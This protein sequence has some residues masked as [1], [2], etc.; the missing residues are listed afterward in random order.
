MKSSFYTVFF[1]TLMLSGCET[2][3]IAPTTD[4]TENTETPAP[5]EPTPAPVVVAPRYLYVA[6]GSCYG[7]DVTAGAVATGSNTVVRY[8]IDTGAFDSLITDYNSA[9]GEAP[10]AIV[11]YSD[12]ELLVLVEST[13][14]RRVDRVNKMTGARSSFLTNSFLSTQARDLT[15]LADGGLLISRNTAIEKFNS[16]RNRIM[17]GVTSFVVSPAAPCA[18]ATTLISGMT[19]LPGGNFVFAHA[20]AT[21]NNRIGIIKSTGYSVAGD[22][23]AG[24]TVSTTTALPTALITEKNSGHVLVA[25]G[26]ATSAS[27][28]IQS[29]V[30]TPATGAV[31]ASTLAYTD[32]NYVTAPS[33]LVQDTTTNL[34]YV[35]NARA[36]HNSI[37][38]FTYD[39][40]TRLLTRVSP[41]F[42]T[43]SIYT[44]CVAGM[45][46]GN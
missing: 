46:I 22:C 37:E 7:G 11:N 29:F 45:A 13:G 16:N 35:A 44:R 8:N 30:I 32:F 28:F 26:S 25:A 3:R 2:K 23:M 42:V 41:T 5:E 15:S 12:D 20:A 14:G 6:S 4:T 40:T 36:T 1:A 33:R 17:G 27:N 34:I 18:T 38:K 43:N 19:E 10:A 9:G 39:A 31:T 24:V 21:P